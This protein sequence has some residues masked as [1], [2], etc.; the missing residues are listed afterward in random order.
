[1]DRRAAAGLSLGNV[2]GNRRTAGNTAGGGGPPVWRNRACHGRCRSP[3]TAGRAAGGARRLVAGA[4]GADHPAGNGALDAGDP[5][6]ADHARLG[7]LYSLL[8][9]RYRPSARIA[10]KSLK[11]KSTA[12]SL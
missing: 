11:E 1:G 7:R 4:D 10:G 8:S 6:R 5:Q 9:S 2:D 12:S 3:A